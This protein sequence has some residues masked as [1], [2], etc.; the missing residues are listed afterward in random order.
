[1]FASRALEL[2]RHAVGVEKTKY[3]TMGTGCKRA[4]V[5]T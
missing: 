5:A 1:V 3:G 2:R 4:N